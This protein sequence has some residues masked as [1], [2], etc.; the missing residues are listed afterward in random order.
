MTELPPHL[1]PFVLDVA[2]GAE[3]RVERVGALDFHR[4][5]GSARTGAVLLVHGGPMPADL[6]VQPRDWPVFQGYA[7]AIA[8]R[9]QVAVTVD[10]SLIRGLDQLTTAADDVEAAVGILRADPQVNPE[11]VV[12]WF[13]SGAGLLAGEWLDSRPDWLR[14]VALTYPLLATPPGVDELVSAAEVI[15]KY[16]RGGGAGK[17]SNKVLPV[18][19]TRVG[20]EREELARPVAEFVSAGGA[21]LDIIDVPKGQHGFDML[22]HSEESRAAVTKALDWAIAHLGEDPTAP[23]QLPIPAT[24]IPAPANQATKAPAGARA[25]GTAAPARPS[26]SAA[27][28]ATTPSGSAGTS[29]ASTGAATASTGLVAPPAARATVPTEAATVSAGSA[30]PAAPAAE[31]AGGAEK[32]AAPASQ[33]T[34]PTT[35]LPAETA[36]SRV[37]ARVHAAFEAHDLEAFLAMYSPTALLQFADGP[38]MR[39]RRSLREHYRPQFEAGDCQREL[40]HRM[41]VGNWVVEQTVTDGTPTVALYQVQDGLI[42]EVRF[43]A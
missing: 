11:R 41:L 43:L 13:F 22:D 9:G 4:P 10:H 33:Q 30:A 37:V 29:S 1:Q 38:V 3:H 6:E 23:S 18:L 25:A 7:A 2:Q 40:V 19:L 14:A 24:T 16:D 17:V 21:A 32:A 20:R 42:T 5:D 15:G 35:S 8:Q 28:T 36:A 26:N 39:G 34:S 31:R 12:L 27:S